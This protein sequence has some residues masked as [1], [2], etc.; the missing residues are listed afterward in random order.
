MDTF[1]L[2]VFGRVGDD[3]EAVHTIRNDMR[4]NATCWHAL[5]L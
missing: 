5:S 1:D 4:H 3:Y 2:D